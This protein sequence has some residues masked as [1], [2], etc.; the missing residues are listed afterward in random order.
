M[1]D[2]I[3][4]NLNPELKNGLAELVFLLWNSRNPNRTFLVFLLTL[5]YM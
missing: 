2:R 1:D 5:M 4:K 3:R